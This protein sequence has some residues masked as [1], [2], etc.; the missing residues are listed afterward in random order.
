MPFQFLFFTS[1]EALHAIKAMLGALQWLCDTPSLLSGIF[2]METS[3]KHDTLRQDAS[4]GGHA[5][6][7]VSCSTSHEL[8]LASAFYQSDLERLNNHKITSETS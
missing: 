4:S 7:P 1:E 2:F 3:T 5:P 8:A 6:F